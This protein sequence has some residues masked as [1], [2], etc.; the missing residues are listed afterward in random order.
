M[1]RKIFA[2]KFWLILG[3]ALMVA[4]WPR[5][6]AAHNPAM[7]LSPSA[8]PVGTFVT[9]SVS[10]FD[11][12]RTAE[13]FWNQE[14]I[15]AFHIGQ[16]GSGS[17]TFSAPNVAPGSYQVL[18]LC[19]TCQPP[20][21]E[22]AEA[23]F[24]V[25]ASEIT[26]TATDSHPNSTLTPTAN[27]PPTLI[28]TATPLATATFTCEQTGACT[29]TPAPTSPP[30]VAPTVT[31]GVVPSLSPTVTLPPPSPTPSATL[32][33]CFALANCTATPTRAVFTF[34]PSATA[35]AT[36]TFTLTTTASHSP[37]SKA[38]PNHT[39]VLIQLAATVTM[40]VVPP[41]LI[42]SPSAPSAEVVLMAS[43]TPHPIVRGAEVTFTILIIG[44]GG[45][46]IVL[47]GL[48]SGW[49]RWPFGKGGKR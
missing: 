46:V 32:S 40:T 47:G 45:V 31:A 24:E 41:P 29:S 36:P 7:S 18:V 2:P 30:T 22:R 12:D 39:A 10:G 5:T 42:T 37:T 33:T 3:V 27:H 16:D 4:G 19:M 6:A 49:L 44:L 48:L 38:L 25:S 20:I 23:W 34:T 21:G 1:A 11:P 17:M 9:I 26:V 43:P 14:E 35:S 15:G 8:G 13:A 28:L